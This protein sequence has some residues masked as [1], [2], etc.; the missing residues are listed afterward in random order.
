MTRAGKIRNDKFSMN[1]QHWKW[2]GPSLITEDDQN[3]SLCL[4]DQQI[5][6]LIKKPKTTN[7]KRLGK[8]LVLGFYIKPRKTL[9]LTYVNKG[10]V[11][12]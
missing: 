1:Q 8:R 2:V 11:D 7:H 12:E 9:S 6:A 3:Y 5:A 10:E 4:I